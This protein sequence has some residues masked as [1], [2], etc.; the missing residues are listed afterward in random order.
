MTWNLFIDDERTPDDV[1]WAPYEIR[2]KYHSEKWVIVRSVPSAMSIIINRGSM[3]NFISFDHDLGENQLTGYKLAQILIDDALNFPDELH[4]Q[5]PSD[6]A[7]Y[8]HSKN[9][10]GKA[11]IEGLLNNYLEFRK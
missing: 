7:F 3:P 9:P 8:V 4:M 10:V 5:F 6:F 2:E 1:T 11:N